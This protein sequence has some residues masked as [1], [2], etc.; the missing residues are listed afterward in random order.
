MSKCV[1][2]GG[3]LIENYSFVRGHIKK[4]DFVIYCDCG[5]LHMEKLGAWP[6]LIVGDFDSHENPHLDV[7]TITL[8]TE[9][10]DTDTVYAVKEGMSRGFTDFL[11]VGALG[12]RFDHTLGNLAILMML[13][14]KGL[15]GMIV[16]DYSEIVV[17]SGRENTT[18]KV[19]DDCKYFSILAAGGDAGGVTIKNAKYNITDA[20]IITDFPLGVSNEVPKGNTAEISIREGRAFLIK[21][22]TE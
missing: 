14:S 9:K 6:S 5:L 21:V 7:E 18:Y 19:S 3:A 4:D 1:I 20:D 17:I 2:V 22:Y 13:E 16:D 12:K 15:T 11:I 10:D 8:P